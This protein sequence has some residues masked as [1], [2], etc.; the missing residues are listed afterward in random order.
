VKRIFIIAE[1]GQ[2]HE[3]SLGILHS[4]IDAVSET[5]VDAIKFQTHIAEAESSSQEPF[6][7]KFSMQDETRFDY[8]KRMSFSLDQ[9]RG[10]KKHCDEKKL[11]FISSPFSLAAVN[12]LEDLKVLR[13]KIASGEIANYLM[14]DKIRRTGKPVLLSTGMSS[15]E[16][17]QKCINFFKPY[18]TPISILQC[19]TAY[20]VAPEKLGLNILTELK[21]RFNLPIGLSDHSGKIYPSLAATVMGA[22]IIE[23]HVTFHKEMFGPDTKASLTIEELKQLVEGIRY[24]EMAIKNPVNKDDVE[25]YQSLK[26]IFGKSLALNKD[27]CKGSIIVFDDLESKKPANC[28]VPCSEYNLVIGKKLKKDISKYSFL[29]YDDIE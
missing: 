25:S 12:I 11:E 29:N 10:I 2:A 23:V 3:G 28:G 15:Y 5:G 4:Y 26:V 24:L 20:P 19:T 14:L 8:W 18:K 16:E 17:I 22:N 27:L 7:I 21:E 9:W 6:R 1:I 13:Y